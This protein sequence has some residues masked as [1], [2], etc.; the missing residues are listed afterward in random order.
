VG[1]RGWF[2]P[3]MMNQ[4]YLPAFTAKLLF[5]VKFDIPMKYAG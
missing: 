4:T 2:A 5:I 3:S 1:V